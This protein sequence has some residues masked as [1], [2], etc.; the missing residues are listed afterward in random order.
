MFK[1][2]VYTI[3]IPVVTFVLGICAQVLL[4]QWLKSS[5]ILFLSIALMIICFVIIFVILGFTDKRFD[6]LEA[7]IQDIAER[8]GLQVEFVEDGPDGVSY[9]KGADLIKGA[10]T[11]ITIVSPWEP[12]SE[13]LDDF[14]DARLKVVRENYYEAMKSQILRHKYDSR[15]FHRRVLQIP[16]GFDDRPLTFKTDPTFYE[17]LK[18]ASEIQEKYPRTCQL[19]RASHFIDMHF[20]IID[21]RY[22]IIPIFSRRENARLIRYG[23]LIFND[24]QGTLVAFLDGICRTLEAR[25]RPITSDQII[26]PSSKAGS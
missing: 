23:A 13:Y 6:R 18:F 19:R 26:F 22:V 14:P 10:K 2:K 7:R 3:G 20:T 25:S 5:D 4:D 9:S 1:S 8:S 12:Y 16:K 24:T 17:Y 21:E 11:S 15:L